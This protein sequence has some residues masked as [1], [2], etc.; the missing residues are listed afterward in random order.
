MG[1]KNS[2]IYKIVAADSRSPRNGRFIEAVGVYNPLTQ[3]M[4]I[5]VKEEKAIKWLK[6]GAQPT[7][8][9]RSLL[10]RKGIILKWHLMKKGVDESGIQIAMEKWEST[11]INRADREHVK[12]Q[13]AAERRKKK[14]TAEAKPAEQPAAAVPTA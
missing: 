9:V 1:K 3:P 8:T 14:K 11:Q 5:D 2:P 6:N 10:S 4:T 12:K 13:K 7:A